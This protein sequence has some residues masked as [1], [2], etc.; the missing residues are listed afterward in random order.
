MELVPD[1]AGPKV[2]RLD[3][4]DLGEPVDAVDGDPERDVLLRDG[5]EPGKLLQQL[6][7]VHLD[8]LFGLKLLPLLFVQCGRIH[9]QAQQPDGAEAAPVDGEQVS[10]PKHLERA[11]D[12]LDFGRFF[13]DGA[14]F[15]RFWVF[16]FFH[17]IFL[18]VP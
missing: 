18:V 2:F 17:F 10:A 13:F 11:P 1:D 7:D 15:S 4:H 16:T 8:Q 14:G 9:L 3:P 12:A 6:P 5:D